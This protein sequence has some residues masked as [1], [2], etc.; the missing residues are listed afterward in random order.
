MIKNC[1]LF[2]IA[3]VILLACKSKTEE[4]IQKP[5]WTKE[6]STQLNSKFS[7][8]EEIKIRLYLKQH[9]N[10]NFKET[11]SGL[12]YWIYQDEEGPT[13][14]SNQVVDVKF[15]MSLLDNTLIYQTEGNEV[16]QFKV[17]KDHVES[18]LMEGI[19]Y[20]SEGDKAQFIIPSPLAH[21]LLGDRNKIPPLEVVLVD[22]EL[23]KVY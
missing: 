1:L 6:Q 13:V 16:S 23:I 20:L 15:K 8:E 12:R 18:G 14:T 10:A 3:I 9:A 5:K 2:F 11:G 21:G 19:K 22:V 17:D 7:N 4:K